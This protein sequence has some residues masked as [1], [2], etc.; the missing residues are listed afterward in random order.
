MPHEL[1]AAEPS[2]PEAFESF[3]DARREAEADVERVVAEILADVRTRGDAA[4]LDYTRRFDRVELSAAGM[5]VPKRELE[6]AAEACDSATLEALDLAAGRIRAFHERQTS[7]TPTS[8]ACASAIAG[9]RWT[10]LGSTCP[11]GR[12]PIPPRC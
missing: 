7:T 11:G 6:A 9:P 1:N 3:L 8:S 4:V 2:F 5:R 12:R 10:R